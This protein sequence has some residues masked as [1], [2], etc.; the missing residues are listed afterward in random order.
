MRGG[1]G[2]SNEL[3]Y[4]LME[5]DD[6]FSAFVNILF[7]QSR[8]LKDIGKSRGFMVVYREVQG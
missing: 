1:V 2:K 8:K 5:N 7:H 6:W 3:S 4:S